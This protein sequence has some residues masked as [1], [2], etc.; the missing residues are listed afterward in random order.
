[1]ARCECQGCGCPNQ[2]TTTDDGGVPVCDQ[3]AEYFVSNDGEVVCGR[4]TARG[5]WIPS[6]T[7]GLKACHD[8][9][10]DI[11]WGCIETG[12]HPGDGTPNFVRGRCS[13]TGRVW[14]NEDRGGW[15]HVSYTDKW[16]G[17]DE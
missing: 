5:C 17:D 15:G 11:D 10:S 7:G 4:M 12:N 8:C 9:Q 2:A 14:R 3:C 13:C 6:A 16:L 1:M